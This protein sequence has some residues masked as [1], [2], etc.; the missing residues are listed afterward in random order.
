M[1]RG[2]QLVRQWELLRALQTRGE[3]IPLRE[4]ADRF[5]VSERTLQRD[6]EILEEL[7]F[8]IEHDA[9]EH[10][11]RY[12]RMPHDYFRSGPF[13]IG[14]T[15]ALSLHLAE[16]LLTP[17]AGTHLADGLQTLLD[18]IR[19]LLPRQAVEHFAA[20]DEVLHVRRTGWTDYSRKA[21]IIRVLEAGARQQ[22]SAE[23]TYR[24]LWRGEEYTTAID[25]YGVVCYDADLFVVGHSHRA[26]ALRIFKVSR[27]VSARPL[28]QSFVRPED[29]Q[30]EEQ[31][32]SSFG[33]IHAKGEPIEIAVRFRGTGASLVEER[34]WHESQRLL[35]LDDEE[36][37]LF[38][39]ESSGPEGL[40]ASFKLSDV[41][42]FKRWILG[43]GSSAEVIRPA[44]LRAE[45]AAELS[46]AAGA[47][48][49]PEGRE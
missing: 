10:G 44:W 22:T 31:F 12:W 9:D 2:D 42:E 13:V 21:E 15:E 34:V 5:A 49:T 29:F 39:E 3:G 48:R 46:S 32:R 14:L 23:I 47:Y 6:F 7:G 8:P 35:W 4:L 28:A 36:E 16:S 17:L 30:L 41:T 27:I 1:A 33:I 40:I 45:V 18:K 19:R 11:K 20:I 38:G 26:A 37:S 25:P 43:F 24:A